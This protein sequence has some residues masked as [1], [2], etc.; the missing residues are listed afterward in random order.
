VAQT[1]FP[2][3]GTSRRALAVVEPLLGIISSGIYS[4]FR[5]QFPNPGTFDVEAIGSGDLSIA[6]MPNGVKV[7]DGDTAGVIGSAIAVPP[8]TPGNVQAQAFILRHDH[9]P[10]NGD[11]TYE[12]V[13]GAE[14]VSNPPFPTIPAD[15]IVL[16]SWELPQSATGMGDATNFVQSDILSIPVPLPESG[17]AGTSDVVAT[18]AT[19]GTSSEAA[20]AD[21]THNAAAVDVSYD[22]TGQSW[23]GVDPT[24]VQDAISQ[25]IDNLGQ[26][27]VF[28]AEVGT[29]LDYTTLDA[30]INAYEAE[31]STKFAI[32]TVKESHTTA[33]AFTCTK[34]LILI[35]TRPE[36]YLSVPAEAS[37][38]GVL[39]TLGDGGTFEGRQIT[40]QDIDILRPGSIDPFEFKGPQVIRLDNAKVTDSSDGTGGG[41]F[42]ITKDAGD[43]IRK[44]IICTRSLIRETTGSSIL[45]DLR[46]WDQTDQHFEL[47]L[48]DTDVQAPNDGAGGGAVFNTVGSTLDA[49]HANIVVKGRSRIISNGVGTTGPALEITYGSDGPIVHGVDQVPNGLSIRDDERSS[50]F[51]AHLQPDREGVGQAAYD[52]VAEQV[53]YLVPPPRGLFVPPTPSGTPWRVLGATTLIPTYNISGAGKEK[54]ELFFLAS[55]RLQYGSVRG[56]KVEDLKLT[57]AASGVAYTGTFISMLG[58]EAH[59]LKGCEIDIQGALTGYDESTF[60]A[61]RVLGGGLPSDNMFRI[62][63]CDWRGGNTSAPDIGSSLLRLE[64]E[65]GL[66]DNCS[67]NVQGMAERI[68]WMAGA[69]K[70]LLQN[71]QITITPNAFVGN[72]VRALQSDQNSIDNKFKD[73]TVLLTPSSSNMTEIFLLSSSDRNHFE[74]VLVN[75]TTGAI[76]NYTGTF[77]S[78]FRNGPVASNHNSF[79]DCHIFNIKPNGIVFDNAGVGDGNVY[80]FNETGNCNQGFNVNAATGGGVDD[81][82][83]IANA[84]NGNTLAD[85]FGANVKTS[86]ND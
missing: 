25:L 68:I 66:V 48:D 31:V 69:T 26:G 43:E 20:R 44:T 4:G 74:N 15:A 79:R 67:F 40:L 65:G 29:G 82:K 8:P 17:G 38:A 62:Q 52:N 47:I 19:N 57:V 35:G 45:F 85:V 30:A 41:M 1:L 78:V 53:L 84:S 76:A 21:H 2:E 60:H 73:W 18:G 72:A 10:A 3:Y 86:L 23:P 83:A 54:S 80:A 6:K 71:I 77:T 59:V 64:A 46:N 55:S 36:P 9:N 12:I 70:N 13:V 81:D 61:V 50:S 34:N 75:T 22:P 24:E 33:G 27:S 56:I 51:V 49:A 63:D 5:T 14:A 32:I 39:V 28:S 7:L 37:A 11:A 58:T 42:L 16:S